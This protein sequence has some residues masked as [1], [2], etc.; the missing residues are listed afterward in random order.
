[1]MSFPFP[2][3]PIKNKGPISSAFIQRDLK[4]MY[5]A[6][7][8]LRALPYGRTSDRSNFLTVLHE[9]IG[10]CS[11]KHA[12]IAALADEI[13]FN[14]LQLYLGIYKMNDENTP[15]IG[16]VLS[17]NE[18]EYIPEAHCYLK[19]NGVEIDITNPQS[20]ISKIIPDILTET[21]IT[22]AQTIEFKVTEHKK[23]IKRWI[24]ET[25]L[26]KSFEQVWAIREKC[27]SALSSR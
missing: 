14:D 22:P 19:Y 3:R 24:L 1:M 11:S 25:H 20:D 2:N 9:Q 18:L 10:T 13:S 21:R 23:F 16:T 12:L 17:S 27:I 8:Y 26:N 7:V 5:D 4:S 15:G 6:T